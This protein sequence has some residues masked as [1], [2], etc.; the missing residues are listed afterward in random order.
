MINR[1]RDIRRQKAMTLADVAGRCEPP[2]RSCCGAARRASSR[3][4][5]RDSPRLARKR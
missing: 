4:V 5:A 3:G 1:I 2:T